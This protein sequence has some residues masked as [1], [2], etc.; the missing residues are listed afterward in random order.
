MWIVAPKRKDIGRKLTRQ[1]IPPPALHDA[2]A[3]CREHP[4]LCEP[5]NRGHRGRAVLS[6]L[7]GRSMCFLWRAHGGE[8]RTA[9]PRRLRGEVWRTHGS[10]FM[11]MDHARCGP[12]KWDAH[13]Q[14]ARGAG[15][16]GAQ[17]ACER[18][19]THLRRQSAWSL[20]WWTARFRSV[21]TAAPAKHSAEAEDTREAHGR[22]R[23]CEAVEE[24]A[25]QSPPSGAP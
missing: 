21:V 19:P 25:V 7:L 8:G 18:R 6:E 11:K 4:L 9:K 5:L 14:Q 22:R 16:R 15:L 20:R 3:E 23:A 24:V 12:L 13:A 1:L 10:S 2:A 17:Q